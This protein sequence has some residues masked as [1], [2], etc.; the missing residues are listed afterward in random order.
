MG[1]SNFL[2]LL[3][4]TSAVDKL[5]LSLLEPGEGYRIIGN[6][7]YHFQLRHGKETFLQKLRLSEQRELDKKKTK[8]GRR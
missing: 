6:D 1:N 7:M 3:H 2:D 8:R 5:V 4:S